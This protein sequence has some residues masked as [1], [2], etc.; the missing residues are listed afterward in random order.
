MPDDKPESEDK[1]VDESAPAEP[2][3]AAEKS[4]KR[5]DDFASLFAASEAESTQQEI[6]VGDVVRGRV[7][8]VGESNA[9]V[10]VGAKGEAVIDLAE[11][12]DPETGAATLA[13]GDEI[14][15]TVVDD[16][17]RSGS[18][19]LKR[20]LGRGGHVPAELE[21][22]FAHGI[23]VEG[24]VSAEKKGGFEVQI[25]PV[26]AFCPGSQIDVRRGGERVP[27]DVYVGQR[28]QFRV[29]KIESQGRNVVVSRRQL[30]EEEAAARAARTWEQLQEGAVLRGTVTSVRP[31]GAFV[32]L[33]GVEGLI[34]IS[35]ISHGH[36]RKPEEFVQAGADVEVKVIK[37][38]PEEQGKRRQVGL[39]LRA[40][41]AD[42]WQSVNE[43]FPVGTTLKGRVSRLEN[44]G[45]FVEISPGVDGLVHVSKMALDRR[46]SHPRQ[47]VSEGD[48]VDVTVVAIDTEKRRIGLSMVEQARNERDAAET[49]ERG[50]QQAA[51]AAANKPRS[52]GTL[53]DLLSATKKKDS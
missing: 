46:V 8:A 52:M 14:E 20:A 16:G 21:Q 41:Q 30:L 33:G 38:G 1:T 12:R 27:G 10:G 29:I 37:I 6:V 36:V 34:H 3:Q 24:L 25:G 35:E 53:G 31:F 19:V 13:V 11:F 39:S 43:R 51:L 47:I 18:I 42:P 32:D 2:E 44:F 15:A 23:P 45:A 28:F 4:D 5:E 40:L 9:F 17:K 48:E 26:H 50:E 49:R 22:A 7:I